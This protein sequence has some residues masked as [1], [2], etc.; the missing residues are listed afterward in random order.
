MSKWFFRCVGLSLAAV[1]FAAC[2]TDSKNDQAPCKTGGLACHC[3]ANE[4]CDDEL[5]CLSGVCFDFSLGQGGADSGQGGASEPSEGG[6]KDEPDEGGAG[7]GGSL[8]GNGGGIALGGGGSFSTAG[9]S[10]SSGAAGGGGTPPVDLFPPNPA[11]CALV[12]SCATC[13]ETVGV[14][15]LDALAENATNQYVK[16]F[17]ASATAATAEYDLASSDAIGAIFF[18]FTTPQDIGSL[19]ISGQGAGGSLEV[20]LVRANGKD[21]CIYPVIGGSLSPAPD[22][23]WGLGAG[24]YAVLPADQIEVRVRATLPGSAA[25]NIT[26]V[27]F[28]P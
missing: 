14:Y 25:L 13:C 1:T 17:S 28:G 5:S 22:T 24:P 12:T 2:G 8:A 6:S 11:G 23:C 18:R 4:T 7:S 19:T 10:G 21:G 3:Y 15:A 20:A 9:S 26:G 16:A 27:T